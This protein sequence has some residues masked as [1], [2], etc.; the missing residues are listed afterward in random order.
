MR[1]LLRTELLVDF[2]LCLRVSVVQKVFTQLHLTYARGLLYFNM[3]VML[4]FVEIAV[5]QTIPAAFTFNLQGS[6]LDVVP[7][8]KQ[9]VDILLN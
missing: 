3:M 4:F 2:S 5:Q 9:L 6:M 7:M 8:Y 1:S